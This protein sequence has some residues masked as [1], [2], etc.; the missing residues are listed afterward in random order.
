LITNVLFSDIKAAIS[1]SPM[2]MA[3]SSSLYWHN[4]QG[5]LSARHYLD[6]ASFA[7]TLAH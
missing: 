7:P 6:S 1:D 2:F 4:E 5:E 3:T